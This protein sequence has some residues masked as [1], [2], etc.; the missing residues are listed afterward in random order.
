M[1]K[2]RWGNVCPTRRFQTQLTDETRTLDRDRGSQ[3][4]SV[5]LVADGLWSV[6][7]LRVSD[8]GPEKVL[9]DS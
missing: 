3:F 4:D 1:K 2:S 7:R 8:R 5:S 9:L 6:P